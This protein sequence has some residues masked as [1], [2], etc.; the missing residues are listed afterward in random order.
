MNANVEVSMYVKIKV[1]VFM[2]MKM[3]MNVEF[4]IADEN[5]D[6]SESRR[7]GVG[8][9]CSELSHRAGPSPLHPL[10]Y[11]PSHLLPPHPPSTPLSSLFYTENRLKKRK[12][13]RGEGRRKAG[14]GTGAGVGGRRVNGP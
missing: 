8:S 14:T 4:E 3:K 6:E 12:G 2:K 5:E 9:I 1:E 11:P 13:R 10:P 7:G